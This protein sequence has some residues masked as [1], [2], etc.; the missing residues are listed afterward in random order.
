MSKNTGVAHWRHGA[1]L[2]LGILAGA[3]ASAQTI[4]APV[5][6]APGSISYNAEGVPTIVAANDFDAAFLTGWA[7]ARDRFWQMDRLRRVGSGTLSELL[8]AAALG[9][10][11]QLRTLGLRRAAWETW[12]AAS[13]ELRGQLKHYA[14]GV[15]FWLA[16]A[17]MPPEYGP[18]EISSAD[19][20][21]PVDSLVIGKLL[22][23]QLSF[24]LDIDN[25][26]TFATYQG[27]GQA[28][29][30]NGAALFF[31]DVFRVAPA[32]G[33]VTVPGFQPTAQAHSKSGQPWWH[34]IEVGQDTLELAQSLRQRVAD[35]PWIEPRLSRRESPLGS[36]WWIIGGQ[37]TASGKP[38]LA[39]D[40]H[41]SLETPTLFWEANIRSDDPRFAEPMDTVGLI[42]PGT[43]LPLLGCTT[44]H[45]WG[46]TTNPIDI[47]DV[48]QEQF[49]LNTYGLPTHTVHGGV[50]EPVLWVVQSFFVNSVGNGVAD[51]VRRTNSIGYTNGGVTVLV[52]RR[53]YGPVL[54][55]QGSGGISVAWMGFRAT[56][57]IETVRAINRA[58]NLDEFRAAMQTFN[59]GSQ[60]WAYA[61]IDGNIAYFAPVSV[62]VRDDLQNLNAPAGGV[63]PFFIRDGTGALRHGWLPTQ[64]PQPGQVRGFEVL[65]FSE[66]PQ[67]VNPASG[68]LANAN[69]DPIGTNLDN[70]PL[71]Q[72]RPGGGLYYLNA[73]YANGMRMGR[74]DRAIQ[75][76]VASGTPITMA[77]MMTLQANNQLL[78]AE[79]LM[80][81]LLNAF[82]GAGG[83]AAW[84]PLAELGASPR[85]LDA[86]ERLAD[87]DFSTPTGLAEG[88]DPFRIPGT[89]PTEAEIRNSSA[90]TI[91]ALWRAYA[92]RNTVDAALTQ[93]GL[94]GRLPG[95][96]QA[97]VAL[98]HHL[99][100]FPQRQGVGASGVNFF[101]APGAPSAVAARDFLLLKS[102]ADALDRLA[103]DEFA[104]AF[105]NST[106]LDD[107]RWGRLHRVVFSHQ[108]GGP[109]SI[110]GPNPFPFTDV[111]PGLPGLA[112]AGGFE[113]VDASSHNARNINLNGFMFGGGPVR[114]FVGEMSDPPVAMQIIPGGQSGVITSGAAY[115]SQ[116]PRWLVNAYKPM[117]IGVDRALSGSVAV[118][119]FTP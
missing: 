17:P 107:Y 100:V 29:G 105:A 68:Y 9:N 108:L 83:A 77:H 76:L 94:G 86:V 22:A 113:A 87:W 20:W 34:G 69:N 89:P 53:N 99:D 18:L 78:D 91:F 79:L 117:D 112:R 102:L 52:P 106:N 59:V 1:V 46:L 19:P 14:D 36:N 6:S 50:P 30:F 4:T 40:P 62:P 74:I 110:P 103:S 97:L 3:S 115:I 25:T 119:E 61:D 26:I 65:P 44:R 84:P 72:L 58:R 13:D 63:P 64:N 70:N 42:A 116:L 8:G 81:H 43:H 35:N 56:G 24:D 104:P 88:F 41:L 85:I 95:G 60:N 80:P 32:D 15:N 82:L 37:H 48:F 21:H 10:D 73:G 54:D 92:I 96:S 27:T 109:F 98:K 23:F 7:H 2:A 49:V 12:A 71:N 51:D 31:E 114:R 39:N 57:E 47:T 16:S 38:I 90:A 118:I 67:A 55:I 45:C 28:V 111:G 11:V 5:L 93:V 75:G 66:L 33:R 101:P